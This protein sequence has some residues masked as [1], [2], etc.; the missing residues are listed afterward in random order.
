MEKG[1]PSNSYLSLSLLLF[2]GGLSGSLKTSLLLLLGLGTVLV[3]ELEQLGSSVL[4]EG[5]RELGDRGG[6]LETLAEDDL[7]AL[8]ADVFG[9]LH[10]AGEVLLGLDV[11]ACR[12]MR[13]HW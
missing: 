2:S 5:V 1:W 4:V 8:K 11:L 10:E 6:N 12:T 9:L 3:K 7:L 13:I